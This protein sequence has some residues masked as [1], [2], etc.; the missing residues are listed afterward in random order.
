LDTQRGRGAEVVV[1]PDPDEH[2]VDRSPE[3]AHDLLQRFAVTDGVVDRGA[4]DLD[5]DYLARHGVAGELDRGVGIARAHA[6][7]L[8]VPEDAHVDVGVALEAEPLELPQVPGGRL[9]VAVVGVEVD[10]ERDVRVLLRRVRN[11]LRH[12]RPEVV[13]VEVVAARSRITVEQR[14]DLDGVVPGRHAAAQPQVRGRAAV[15][16]QIQIVRGRRIAVHRNADLAAVGREERAE[17]EIVR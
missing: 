3:V 12:K 8:V 10:G 14:G 13:E 4:R 1:G 15:L 11:V 6:A 7:P 9:A 5:R 17:V 2:A 16:V